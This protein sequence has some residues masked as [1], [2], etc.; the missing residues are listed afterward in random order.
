MMMTRHDVRNAIIDALEQVSH[1]TPEYYAL[2]H[3]RPEKLAELE[4]F[5][6]KF[7]SEV[8]IKFVI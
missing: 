6:V 8:G 3:L 1:D 5:L 2:N 7:L 4:N